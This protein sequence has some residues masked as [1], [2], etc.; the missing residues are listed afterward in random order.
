MITTNYKPSKIGRKCELCGGVIIPDP[1]SNT[2]YVTTMTLDA[3]SYV[4]THFLCFC[5]ITSGTPGSTKV[6]VVCTNDEQE[7]PNF[8]HRRFW[9]KTKRIRPKA[10]RLFLERL[11]PKARSNP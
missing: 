3:T 6:E 9:I 2:G 5:H 8:E 10:R 4:A 11:K 1:L 7:K